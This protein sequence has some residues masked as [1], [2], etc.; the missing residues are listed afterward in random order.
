MRIIPQQ[1][2]P[3]T[4]PTTRKHDPKPVSGGA[5]YQQYRSC[6]RWE[7]GFTC[8]FCLL[9]EADFVRGGCAEGTGVTWIEHRI[10]Q[11]TDRGARND[12]TNC[13]YSCRFCNGARS[14]NPVEREGAHLLDPTQA[15]W[16]HHFVLEDDF[17]KPAEGDP[18]AEYTNES[19][20]LNESRKVKLRKLRREMYAEYLALIKK[21][22][23]KIVQLMALAETR[24]NEPE[25]AGE[26]EFCA[27]ILRQS[28]Q[29]AIKGLQEY[30]AVPQDAP[31]ECRCENVKLTL[32]TG[33][34][35]QVVEL[36]V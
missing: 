9:H 25:I 6:L 10:P 1:I 29:K 34:E 18:D 31:K 22:P 16:S 27:R 35:S 2:Q 13:I 24:I 8:P 4:T 14:N 19:Y 7:F 3:P 32:P 33:L 30:A 26:L 12:Y 20:N 23:A 21:G 36:P 17:L 11:S 28:I 15:I 5:G